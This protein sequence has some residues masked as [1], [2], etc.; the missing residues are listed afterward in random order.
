MMNAAKTQSELGRLTEAHIHDGL[1]CHA[2]ISDRDGEYYGPKG[3]DR[4]LCDL[5]EEHGLRLVLEAIQDA[6]DSAS[7]VTEDVGD[8][9]DIVPMRLSI[10]ARRIGEAVKALR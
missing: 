2:E 6:A 3:L 4:A 5:V 10:V 8:E 9:Q 1:D 7:D